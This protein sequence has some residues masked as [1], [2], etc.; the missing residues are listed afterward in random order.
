MWRE[1]VRL[2]ESMSAASVVDFPEPV[3]PP[4][5]T[6]PFFRSGKLRT[7]GG[8]P[9]FLMSGSWPVMRRNTPE[10]PLICWKTLARNR[11]PSLFTSCE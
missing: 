3:G 11:R 6:S 4:T 10:M 8:S 1:A 7:I 5:R 9:R 2:M